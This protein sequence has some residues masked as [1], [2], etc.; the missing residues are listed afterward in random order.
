MAKKKR[1]QNKRRSNPPAR[2][3]SRKINN[4]PDGLNDFLKKHDQILKEL[5]I[6]NAKLTPGSSQWNILADNSISFFIQIESKPFEDLLIACLS[7]FEKNPNSMNCLAVRMTLFL[8]KKASQHA[9]RT[10]ECLWNETKKSN[11]EWKQ[12]IANELCS[13]YEVSNTV[14]KM[15]GSRL[16]DKLTSEMKRLSH[17]DESIDSNV[18][19]AFVILASRSLKYQTVL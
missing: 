11:T 1:N 3:D 4:E 2:N 5:E 13:L 7:Y 10:I 17:T 9:D 18:F 8:Q 19:E 12:Y 16:T 14:S 6:S 15:C